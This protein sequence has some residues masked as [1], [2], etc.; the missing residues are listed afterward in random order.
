MITETVVD[1]W[2]SEDVEENIFKALYA[3][4]ED[5]YWNPTFG[6]NVGFRDMAISKVA[7][8]YFPPKGRAFYT[9][10]IDFKN[11]GLP[12]I[13][14]LSGFND[15]FFY[16]SKE[17]TPSVSSCVIYPIKSV[18]SRKVRSTSGGVLYKIVFWQFYE[19]GVPPNFAW[20]LGPDNTDTIILNAYVEVNP[21]MDTVTPCFFKNEIRSLKRSTLRRLFC[22]TVSSEAD[23]KFLWNVSMHYPFVGDTKI[24]L[25]FGVK[26]EHVKSLFYARDCPL[27]ETGRKR[28][29]QHWV[30]SHRR[31]LQDNTEINIEKYLRGVNE[32]RMYGYDFI[33]SSPKK[34]AE[35]QLLKDRNNNIQNFLSAPLYTDSDTG[36]QN[37]E[38][39]KKSEREFGKFMGSINRSAYEQSKI[40][41]NR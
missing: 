30:S 31:R 24:W 29:I 20:E 38:Q 27:S 18:P 13:C 34:L 41:S 16:G 23:R 7:G 39:V 6:G 1:I 9:E 26:E 28:P 33:I 36:R 5:K 40:L 2:D 21:R 4:S 11:D 3:L 12:G 37:R 17:Y 22:T 25:D 14:R 8:C 15:F 10:S 35:H 32:F 19:N